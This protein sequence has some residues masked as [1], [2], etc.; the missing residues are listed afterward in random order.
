MYKIIS[1]KRYDTETALMLGE[2]IFSNPADNEYVYEALYKTKKGAYFLHYIGGSNTKYAICKGGGSYVG[3]E[4]I[5]PMR[6]K[7]A[8]LWAERNLDPD[9][10]T[11]EFGRL[12]KEG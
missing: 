8:M 9:E 5:A 4:S 12:I 7:E 3:S 10:V 11:K 1:G 6:P 2:N